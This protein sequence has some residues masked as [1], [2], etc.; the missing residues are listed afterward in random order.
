M[1]NNDN[2]N[3]QD[4]NNTNVKV[5]PVLEDIT[6][7]P[8]VPPAQNTTDQNTPSQ[9]GTSSPSGDILN[10]TITNN[11]LGDQTIIS[12]PAPKKKFAGGKIIATILGLFLVVGGIG[13]GVYL[14]SQNQN[15]NKFAANGDCTTRAYFNTVYT[16]SNGDN[17][18]SCKL[19]T[20]TFDSNNIACDGSGITC[21]QYLDQLTQSTGV[22]KVYGG[23]YSDIAAC[24]NPNGQSASFRFFFD[25]TKCISTN[26]RY[27]SQDIDVD[28][29][30]HKT[31]LQSLAQYQPN[32]KQ[33]CYTSKPACQTDN[34]LLN[35]ASCQ[36]IKAY[37]FSWTQLTSSE[38]SSLKTGNSVIFCATGSASSGSFDKA[39]FT[40]NNNQ[41]AET[42]LVRPSS[43]DFC[44]QYTIPNGTTS[45][46][47]TAQLHHATLGWK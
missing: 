34:G 2:Q 41:L 21:D 16:D 31:C 43:S 24:T 42:T 30:N 40:I 22:Q 17:S 11:T 46:K 45:F 12:T 38:L 37:G 35:S 9:T 29:I 26:H 32:A 5:S 44:Q 33:V 20:I 25:G 47:V 15:P 23:C 36:N 39:R 13:A 3:N 6:T 4:Q 19:S 18:G 7:P 27:N 14:S 8:M 10:P 28:D 1:P